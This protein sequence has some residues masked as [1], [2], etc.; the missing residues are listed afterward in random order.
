MKKDHCCEFWSSHSGVTE[1]SGHL[2]C[3]VALM[4]RCSWC[5]KG[6]RHPE[7]FFMDHLTCEDE[8]PMF[9]QNVGNHLPATVAHPRRLDWPYSLTIECFLFCAWQ[10]S[11]YSET[12][13]CAWGCGQIPH[14]TNWCVFFRYDHTR[15]GLHLN[16][17]GEEKLVNPIAN[18][19]LCRLD[20][21]KVCCKQWCKSCAFSNWNPKSDT[22]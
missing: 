22:D 10:V 15:H 21:G 2:G 19:V 4:V 11:E 18:R 7:E 9:L 20:S 6:M 16:S 1:E 14:W 12:S 8:G 3:H 17:E 13:A 5:F